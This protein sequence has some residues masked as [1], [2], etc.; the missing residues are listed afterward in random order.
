MYAPDPDYPIPDAHQ[1]ADLTNGCYV[2]VA[3]G[4][5]CFWAE[6]AQI[7]NNV[8]TGTIRRELASGLCS[9]TFPT[10]NVRFRL[11]QITNTGCGHY[12]WC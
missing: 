2:R 10:D 6:I 12:C 4:G 9:S 3:A 7:D 5:H 1:I 11:D 8:A